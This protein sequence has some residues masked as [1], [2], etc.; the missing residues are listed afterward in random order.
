MNLAF[1]AN[2]YDEKIQQTIPYYNV[3]YLQIIDLVQ[4][5]MPNPE[6]WL[7][8]GCGSGKMELMCAERYGKKC[9][10][11]LMCD[12][13]EEMLNIARQNLKGKVYGRFQHCAAQ[14]IDE[15]ECFDV[16]TAIFVN[17]YLDRI[18]RQKSLE[19][20]FRAL[21][22]GGVFITFENTAPLTQ[23]GQIIVLERWKNYQLSMGKS[24]EGVQK[25][26][27][28]YGVSYFP[29]TIDEHLRLLKK[30]GF[31]YVEPFWLSYSQAGIYAVK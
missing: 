11:F 19:N 24:N 10:A 15:L 25:H 28:R 4:T 7:D 12:V 30:N 31:E 6:A 14:D 3:M 9:P 1:D 29:V 13:F 8:I 21:K 17:H 20:S 16:V 2:M 27:E 22:K 5:V 18:E 23:Q 26:I